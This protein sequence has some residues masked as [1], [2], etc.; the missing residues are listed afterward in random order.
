L[1]G[2]DPVR[3]P[4]ALTWTRGTRLDV[5]GPVGKFTFP[6]APAEQRFMFIAGGTG[7]APLRSMLRCALARPHEEIAVIYSARSPEEFAYHEELTDLARSGRIRLRQTV[8][9]ERDGASWAG[10]RGRI[11]AGDLQALKAHEDALV[12]ICGP[13][14]FVDDTRQCLSDLGA[15]AERIRIE[16]W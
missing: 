12:F 13:R 9:R 5:E 1:V 4:Q 7:V 10:G 16:E 11:C 14:S 3:S 8:T 6:E 2:F 15:R